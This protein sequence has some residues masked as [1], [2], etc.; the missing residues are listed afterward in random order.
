MVVFTQVG[1]VTDFVVVAIQTMFPDDASATSEATLSGLSTPRLS[2]SSA[3]TAV[4]DVSAIMLNDR[5]IHD[6]SVC[7]CHQHSTN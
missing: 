2:A 7:F 3:T 5:A 6:V 4:G 1:W